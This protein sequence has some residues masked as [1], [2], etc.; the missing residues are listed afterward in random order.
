MK[1]ILLASTLILS[2][3]LN[4]HGGELKNITVQA[5]VDVV[6]QH[7]W[8]GFSSSTNTSIEPWVYWE[9]GNWS[10]VFWGWYDRET[11]RHLTDFKNDWLEVDSIFMYTWKR[12][13]YDLTLGYHDYSVKDDFYSYS[14][15]F[16]KITLKKSQWKPT[17]KA[18]YDPDANEGYYFQAGVSKTKKDRDWDYSFRFHV[19]YLS[20]YGKRVFDN[21]FVPQLGRV[22]GW[23][24]TTKTG[25][26]DIMPSIRF[27]KHLDDKSSISLTLRGSILPRKKTYYYTQD[28]VFQWI[29]SYVRDF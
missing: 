24:G 21:K 19:G 1:R 4:T 28:D 15:W 22:V 23:T 16:T 6:S 2:I 18:Y 3:L 5:G 10:G 8:R 27:R 13:K 12:K 17:F 7:V 25:W 29:V 20:S 26:A 11:T 14:D 9:K